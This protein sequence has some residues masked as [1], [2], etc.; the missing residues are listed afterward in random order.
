MTLLKQIMLAI[1]SF[2][3][4]IFVAVGILNFSD[5]VG[6][7]GFYKLATGKKRKHEKDAR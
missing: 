6:G 4:L 1:I 5:L 2:M 7:G 3:L